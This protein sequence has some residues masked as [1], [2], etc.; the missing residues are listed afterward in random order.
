LD[1]SNE[2]RFN[3]YAAIIKSKLLAG[4]LKPSPSRGR[5]KVWESFSRLVYENGIETTDAV[6]C[7]TCKNI[8]IFDKSTTNLVKHKCYIIT[9]SRKRSLPAVGVDFE[10]KKK[11]TK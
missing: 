1:T 10:T 3:E 8:Y 9:K 2:S 7:N 4:E 6:V 5:S 11:C